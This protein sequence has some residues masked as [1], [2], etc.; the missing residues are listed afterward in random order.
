MTQHPCVVHGG[1][2]REIWHRLGIY[3]L[4]SICLWLFIKVLA[5]E[6]PPTTRKQLVTAIHVWRSVAKASNDEWLAFDTTFEDLD[7]FRARLSFSPGVS[8]VFSTIR[9]SIDLNHWDVFKS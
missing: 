3:V 9:A 2:A 6:G 4:K 7:A 8:S 1:R 5:D